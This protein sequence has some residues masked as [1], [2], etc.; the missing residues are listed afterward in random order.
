M[1][2]QIDFCGELFEVTPEKPVIIGR[3]ADLVIDEDNQ[4]LHRRFLAVSSGSGL[5]WIENIGGQVAATLADDQ[6][7]VQ[8]W[9][10]P[11][12]KVPVVFPRSVVYFTAGPTTYDFEILVEEPPFVPVAPASAPSHSTT[13]GR[14]TFT[15]DQKLLCLALAEDMLRRGVHGRGSIPPSS[16]AAER[17]GWTI[18]KFNRKLDNV[19]EKLAKMG[20]RGLTSTAGT[21]ASARRS[22]LVEYVLASRLV[23]DADLVVLDLLAENTPA[24]GNAS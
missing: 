20:V 4:F 5:I 15:H 21:P 23:T 10:A 1:K 11:G 7:L 9:L 6:G 24:S 19:C 2:A 3:D 12:A 17:L 14:V 22:R 13:I 8:T 16:Q 18:T